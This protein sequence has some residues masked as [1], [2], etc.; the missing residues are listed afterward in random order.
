MSI[1]WHDEQKTWKRAGVE[2]HRT[3]VENDNFICWRA[4]SSLNWTPANIARQSRYL[5][6]WTEKTPTEV[7]S[8]CRVQRPCKPKLPSRAYFCL[9]AASARAWEGPFARSRFP[10]STCFDPCVGRDGIGHRRSEQGNSR[11]VREY[12][13]AHSWVT[14]R[15]LSAGNWSRRLWCASP[16]ENKRREA[17]CAADTCIAAACRREGPAGA[18]LG[19]WPWSSD[20]RTDCI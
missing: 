11:A 15:D 4:R 14:G 13:A 19:G 6:T 5:S 7:V 16:A 20:R 3:R 9:P 1:T 2:L 10:S 17:R 8:C 12:P 18:A